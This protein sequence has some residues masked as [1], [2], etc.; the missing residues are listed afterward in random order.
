[1]DGFDKGD[2]TGNDGATWTGKTPRLGADAQG[3]RRNDL[4]PTYAIRFI[5]IEDLTPAPRRVRRATRE[6]RERIKRSIAAFGC[7]RPVLIRSSGAIIDGH[8]IVEAVRELGA[9][10]VPCIVIDHLTE[11]EIRQLATTLNRTQETGAWDDTALVVE[12]EELVALEVD[13]EVTGFEVAEI[14]FHL[15]HFALTETESDAVE[16]PIDV[17][18]GLETPVTRPGDV[19]IAGV[20]RV[21]CGR[22]QD[23]ETGGNLAGLG[24]AAV[25]I[26]DPPYNVRISGH[27]STVTLAT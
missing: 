22:A 17:A 1:M 16:P 21:I 4:T 12:F 26:T 13:L 6:Q 25:L 8:I 9:K 10:V 24:P 23:L 14:D 11:I 20:H 18:S 27:V 15:G 7:V 19:W 3:P 2:D 5:P